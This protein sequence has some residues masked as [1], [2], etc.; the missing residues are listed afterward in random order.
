V[1]GAAAVQDGGQRAVL[2]AVGQGAQREEE[3]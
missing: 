3:K 2:H 1:I